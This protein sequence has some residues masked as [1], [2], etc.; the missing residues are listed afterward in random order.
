MCILCMYRETVNK[1]AL[2]KD[3]SAEANQVISGKL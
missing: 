3:F 2:Q 1:I